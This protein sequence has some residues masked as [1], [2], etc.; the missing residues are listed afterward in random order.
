[1]I[2]TIR[3]TERHV[4]ELWLFKIFV[5]CV[6]YQNYFHVKLV[7]MNNSYVCFIFMHASWSKIEQ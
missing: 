3:S 5:D 1:M 4:S 2:I 6:G 7:E